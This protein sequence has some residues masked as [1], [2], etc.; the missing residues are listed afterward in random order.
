[1]NGEIDHDMKAFNCVLSAW[2]AHENELCNY[3]IRQLGDLN[4]S[5]DILQDVFLK[6]MRQGEGFC[7]ITQPRAW[8]FTVARNLLVDRVR[9]Q[10]PHV[11][12]PED[13]ASQVEARAP[14]DE[15][16]NCLR[17]NL[18]ELAPDDRD[19]IEQ[20]DLQGIKQVDY[21]KTRNLS[22]SAVKSR[23]LRARQRLRAALVKN[24][25]V[26]FDDET[27]EVCCHTPRDPS[28]S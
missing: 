1:M 3:L 5:E 28:L 22:L 13:I 27:G 24:C 10:K 11:E 15:L 4:A 26:R 25:Q 19:I 6:A 21:A 12:L 20:C 9:M 7:R 18:A 23:L 14:V 2:Y 8:L 16:D 17:R